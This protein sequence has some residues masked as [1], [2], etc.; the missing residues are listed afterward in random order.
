MYYRQLCLQRATK[1]ILWFGG[2][3][4][5][6]QLCRRFIANVSSWLF[7]LSHLQLSEI[8]NTH[9][10][11]CFSSMSAIFFSFFRYYYYS[12]R[13]LLKQPI[14]IVKYGRSIFAINLLFSTAFSIQCKFPTFH[15]QTPS[16][17]NKQKKIV[18][19]ILVQTDM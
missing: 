9:N 4:M 18:F 11:T 14:A 10:K 1:L 8:S 12:R 19:I 6:F 17:K 5:I 13:N 16:L 2:V 3:F 7:T 15:K